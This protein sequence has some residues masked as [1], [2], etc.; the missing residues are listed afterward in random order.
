MALSREGAV[1]IRLLQ[2]RIAELEAQIAVLVARIEELEQDN[3]VLQEQ[4]DEA[5]RTAALQAASSPA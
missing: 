3:R 2:D 1:A 4:L 5:R